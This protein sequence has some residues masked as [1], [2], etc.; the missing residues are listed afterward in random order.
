M[1]KELVK[2]LLPPVLLRFITGFFY[3]WH[4]N[5]S[6]WKTALSKCSGYDSR[7][8]LDK[9]KESSLKVKAGIVPFE[10]DSVLFNEVQYSFPVLSALM[11]IALQNN[12][13]LNV[14]DFGGSLGSSY[15]QN[16]IFFDS[17]QEV[18]WCVVEQS[19]FVEV[20]KE[21]FSDEKLK[22][23]YTMDECL[24]KND[25]QVILLSSVLQYI[26]NPYELLKTIIASRIKYV[27]FDRTQFISGNDRITIQKVNPSIYRA[28]YP[29][30]FLNKP[31]FKQFMSEEYDLVYEF[32]SP[33]RANI[34]SE[35]RGFLYKSKGSNF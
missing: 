9:V 31:K 28:S 19:G 3:G 24:G 10:R 35:F 29:C 8:I 14:L 21:T 20:G 13:K 25:I 30:W 22:F 11:W 4:G 5:Y 12:G 17:L 2:D 23:Y 27:L 15:Y 32:I 7:L 6:D 33:G 16:K 34:R 1:F 26:E 18:K